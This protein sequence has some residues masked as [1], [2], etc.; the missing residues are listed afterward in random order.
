MPHYTNMGYQR[1]QYTKKY[2]RNFA[3]KPTNIKNFPELTLKKKEFGRNTHNLGSTFNFD[4][5]SSVLR[6]NLIVGFAIFFSKLSANKG[7]RG[8]FDIA[9]ALM[10]FFF[11]NL[12]KA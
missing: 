9:D 2:I 3:E 5:R 11:K 8:G 6:P 4:P 1:K 10:T 7:E 12:D